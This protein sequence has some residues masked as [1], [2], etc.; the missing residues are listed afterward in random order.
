M[1]AWSADFASRTSKFT[2]P[3]PRTNLPAEAARLIYH[4]GSPATLGGALHKAVPHLFD[5]DASNTLPVLA[6][7]L[8]RRMSGL[9]IEPSTSRRNS[10]TGELTESP[11]DTSRRESSAESPGA[12]PS[13]GTSGLARETPEEGNAGVESETATPRG[14]EVGEGDEARSAKK[15]AGT[16]GDSEVR[17]DVADRSFPNG[18]VV[19]IQGTEPRWDVPLNWLSRNLSHPD[20]FLHISIWKREAESQ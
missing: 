17:G 3:V 13:G 16:E 11:R 2:V 15:E 14:S 7:E 10:I 1:F 12:I 6:T 8:S 5:E 19:R 9:E 18:L 4:V 20:H